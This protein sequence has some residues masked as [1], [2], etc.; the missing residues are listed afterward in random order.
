MSVTSGSLKSTLVMRDTL[1][2]G[3]SNRESMTLSD[4]SEVKVIK[5]PGGGHLG[6]W[7]F[8]GKDYEVVEKI[9]R[10]GYAVV[11]KTMCPQDGK[12]YA[13]KKINLEFLSDRDHKLAKEEA[14]KL[15]TLKSDFVIA[16]R[17]F[18]EKNTIFFI[19]MDYAEGGDL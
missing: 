19:I 18:F 11:Y 16:L 6:P 8:R 1:A 5:T 14:A 10:G 2:L 3:S 7:R 4:P 13:M 15:Q 17:G 9:G 12:M